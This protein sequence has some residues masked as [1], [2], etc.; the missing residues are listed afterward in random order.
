MG[1]GNRFTLE[2]DRHELACQFDVSCDCH[3]MEIYDC[4]CYEDQK[5]F[6][7]DTIMELPLA[8][9][10]GLTDDRMSIYY[11]E[12]YMIDLYADHYGDRIV[13]DFSYQRDCETEGLQEYNYVKTYA[14]I[15]RHINKHTALILGHGYT[16]SEIGVGQL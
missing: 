5:M 15:C 12:M 1:A 9:K 13:I 14:R 7:I 10:Y 16:H 3:E 2:E 6:L 8:R 4:D 11:G